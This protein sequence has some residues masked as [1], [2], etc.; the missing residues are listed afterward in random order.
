MKTKTLHFG[1]TVRIKSSFESESTIS[2]ST[3]EKFGNY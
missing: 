2:D 1:N 3:I